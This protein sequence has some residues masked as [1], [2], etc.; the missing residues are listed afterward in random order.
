MKLRRRLFYLILFTVIPLFG[1]SDPK[2]KQLIE[3]TMSKNY[4][5]LMSLFNEELANGNTKILKKPIDGIPEP[6]DSTIFVRAAL[7]LMTSTTHSA[8][9][10]GLLLLNNKNSVESYFFLVQEI[11]DL[12]IKN[13]TKTPEHLDSFLYT[14]YTEQFDEL[15]DNYK[16]K[17][18]Q[19][20]R[21]DPVYIERINTS[22]IREINTSKDL[23]RILSLLELVKIEAPPILFN[24]IYATESQLDELI[25]ARDKRRSS[26]SNVNDRISRIENKYGEIEIKLAKSSYL[27]RGYMIAQLASDPPITYYEVRGGNGTTYV[28]MT[29]ETRFTSRGYFTMRV[30]PGSK[31]KLPTNQSYGGFDKNIQFLTELRTEIWNKYQLYTQEVRPLESEL[32]SLQGSTNYTTQIDALESQLAKQK[33]ELFNWIKT[34]ISI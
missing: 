1:C 24:Q 27:F 33:S 14:I 28:L 19:L 12:S 25:D 13:G 4:S 6:S 9:N 20:I 16:S 2:E 5:Q 26:F 32:R 11:I 30:V 7:T 22:I 18:E 15:D 34:N 10:T 17:L 23:N 29:T 8:S 3:L 21:T 31:A